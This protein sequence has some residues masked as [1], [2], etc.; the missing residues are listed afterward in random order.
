MDLIEG[1]ID[2]S[3]NMIGI[4]LATAIAGIIVGTVSLTGIGQEMADFV[5]FL[6]GGNLILLLIFLAKSRIWETVA[7]LVV[8]FALFRP[9]FFMNQIQPLFTEIA[10][11]QIEQTIGDAARGDPLR[12]VIS[13]PNAGRVV[14]HSNCSVY[15]VRG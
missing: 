1:M 3:R 9:G 5:E 11:A 2:G 4:G 12:V 14:R 15:V 13:G 8:A 7:L 10:P 6:S